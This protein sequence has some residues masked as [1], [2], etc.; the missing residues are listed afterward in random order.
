MERPGE[1]NAYG[2]YGNSRSFLVSYLKGEI[3]FG[4]FSLFVHISINLEEIELTWLKAEFDRGF[5]WTQ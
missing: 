1:H 3:S 5:L 4:T 2:R